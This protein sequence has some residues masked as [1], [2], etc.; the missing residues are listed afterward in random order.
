[1]LALVGLKKILAIERKEDLLKSEE[2]QSETKLVWAFSGKSHYQL[3]SQVL[4]TE[5]HELL[6][7]VIQGTRQPRVA[8]REGAT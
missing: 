3:A 5:E 8:W 4:Y 6:L 7:G 1:M 2:R